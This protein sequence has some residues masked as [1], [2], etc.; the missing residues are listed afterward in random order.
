M[1]IWK[2]VVGKLWLTI[3]GL[4]GIV[5][6]TVGFFLLL[7]IDLT[8]ADPVKIERMFMF[9]GA[10]G[11]LLTTF[12]AFFLVTKITQPLREMIQA[13]NRIARG[14]YSVRLT[15]R[16]SDE[17]GEL[18]GALNMMAAELDKLIRDLQH[19]RDHL[20]GVLRSMSDAVITFDAGG[21]VIMTN[22]KGE[23]LLEA[24][25]AVMWEEEE[26]GESS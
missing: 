18:S 10:V 14:E 9:T 26:E 24:W 11:F 6:C 1:A 8:F 25:N 4:V 22:P 19:E 21:N 7:Y 13:A 5:I 16:S 3:I 23:N 12:F 17:I 2:T 20:S 15:Y